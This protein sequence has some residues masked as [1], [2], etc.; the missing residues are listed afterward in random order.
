MSKVLADS[1][2]LIGLFRKN[3]SAIKFLEKLIK[4]K[5][6]L[7]TTSLNVAELSSSFVVKEEPPPLSPSI[8]PINWPVLGGIIGG[9]IVV[10]LPLESAPQY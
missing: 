1:D 4:K 6:Y 5:S 10:G 9:V 8:G 7:Y 3:Q 2:F